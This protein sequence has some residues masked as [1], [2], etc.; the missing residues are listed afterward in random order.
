MTGTIKRIR[1]VTLDGW[2]DRLT[3]ENQ[4]LKRKVERQRQ[5][6]DK[7]KDEALRAKWQFKED[8][9][10]LIRLKP[11][12]EKEFARVSETSRLNQERCTYLSRRIVEL[13]QEIGELK[14]ANADKGV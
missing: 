12:R 9:E 8:R 2:L 11:E 6:I 1:R 7:L 4:R 14:A 10:T 3:F 5:A 13:K